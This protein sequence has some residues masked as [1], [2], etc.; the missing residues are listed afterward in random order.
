MLDIWE[1]DRKQT[2]LQSDQLSR[3]AQDWEWE[4]RAPGIWYF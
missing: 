1:L 3:I 4:W 2:I